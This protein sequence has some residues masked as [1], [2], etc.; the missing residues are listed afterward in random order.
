MKRTLITLVLILLITCTAFA[1]GTA[2]ES[3]KYEYRY[4]IDM[5]TAGVLEKGFVG[6]MSD[7]LPSGVMIEYMEVGVFKSL[8]LDFF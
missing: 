1:Q 5:P 2:G 3:A 8:S 6:V 4:L 7:I